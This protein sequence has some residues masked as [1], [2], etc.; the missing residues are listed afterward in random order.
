M[1]ISRRLARPLLSATFIADGI[2]AVRDP[3]SHVDRVERITPL[4]QSVGVPPSLTRDPVSLVRVSGG[5]TT[6]A[7]L[8]L[9][10]GRKPRLA[11]AV[12]AA[13]HLPVMLANNPVWTARDREERADMRRGLIRGVSLL[14][15]LAIAA[16]DRDGKPSLTWRAANHREHRQKVRAARKND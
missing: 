6:V 3:Q 8:M 5:I 13:V 10:T 15:G 12:L 7:G 9:A 16:L 4:L 14:G 2:D 1:S 11:A